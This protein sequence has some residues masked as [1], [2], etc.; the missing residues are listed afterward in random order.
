MVRGASADPAT[1]REL[2]LA[3][4][5]A[6]A[7]G[8]LR[9]V[10][11]Q[12]LPLAS[13][14]EAHARIEGRETLGKTLLPVRAAPQPAGRPQHSAARPQSRHTL[15]PPCMTMVSFRVAD[16]DAAEVQRWAEALGVDRSELLR[17]AVHAHLARLRS[18]IDAS[19]WER[20]PFTDAEL[21]LAEVADW[22][23]AED[24]ADWDDA[25]G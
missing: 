12:V 20:V 5:S 16:A 25:T 11:G 6:A 7:E 10:I 4:L 24:W 22:G 8:R 21:L 2:T 18:E 3:A 9:P 14:A 23:P 1:L 15:Y 19:R 13:A 17:D